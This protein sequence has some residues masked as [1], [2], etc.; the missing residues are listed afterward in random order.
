MASSYTVG[1]VEIID[2]LGNISPVSIRASNAT[3]I[4]AASGTQGTGPLTKDYN[5]VTSTSGSPSAVTLPVPVAGRTVVILNKGNYNLSIYPSSGCTI[6][7][8]AANTLI[9]LAPG[10]QYN[11]TASSATAWLTFKGLTGFTGSQGTL[12]YTGS[13]G[14]QGNTGGNGLQGTTGFTGSQGI[15]GPTGNTGSA[16]PS[17]SITTTSSTTS[18]YIVGVSN[19][20][21]Q[22]PKYNPNITVGA[23]GGISAAGTSSFSVINAGGL[24]TTN[25]G[26]ANPI[27]ISGV[28]TIST[29]SGLSTTGSGTLSIAG[30]S[31]FTGRITTNGG[32]TVSGTITSNGTISTSSNISTTAGGTLSIAGTS[33]LTG[34]VT[35]SGGIS[36]TGTIT[37]TGTIS[38]SGTGGLSIAG[39]STFTGAVTNSGGISGAGSITTSSN[40][41]T[42]GSGIITSAGEIRAAGDITAY[43]SDDRLKTRLGNLENALD[44]ITSLQGFYYE[45]NDTAVA[46]G[47]T[48]FREVGLSAQDVQKI[49]P[50]VV[51]PA[52]VDNKYLT[53]NYAKLVPLIV[54]SIK[55]LKVELD[56]LKRRE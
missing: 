24:V 1:G 3:G 11:F 25:G 54:E 13:A 39:S 26:L 55:E 2:D 31:T 36:N 35:T 46:L 7:A 50:E 27:G 43:Y 47:Y 40:I 9:T 51:V 16:G 14:P 19:S 32:I 23:D 6:D 41:S 22:T 30:T 33:T 49:L 38:T 10:S 5:V 21:T 15:Q 42:S 29:S 34:A 45:A 28:G 8:Q 12:G 17:N 52:P 37:S 18:L 20:S 4:S 56:L 48:K 44:K 53:F